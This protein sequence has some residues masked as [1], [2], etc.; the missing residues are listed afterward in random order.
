LVPRDVVLDTGPVV[1]HLDPRDQW[2]ERCAAAWLDLV[3]H[4][5]TTEAVVAEACHLVLRSGAAAEVPLEF[6]LAAGIPILGLEA[7][8]HR[9]AALL[10]A[11]YAN[12][13]M[14]YADASLVVLAD[15]LELNRV[16]TTDRRGFGVYR[17]ARGVAFELLPE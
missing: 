16:F 4:C 9:Q 13:P 2:H 7:A 6:L 12:L 10:M 3:E 14:D 15:A 1:A 11:R 17:G 8:G 5:V